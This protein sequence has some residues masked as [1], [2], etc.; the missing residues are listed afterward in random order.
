LVLL[1]FLSLLG[2]ILESEMM[3]SNPAYTEWPSPPSVTRMRAS[4]LSNKNHYRK[5]PNKEYC[6]E[7]IIEDGKRRACGGLRIDKVTNRKNPDGTVDRVV[8]GKYCILCKYRDRARAAEEKKKQ[9]HEEYIKRKQREM[10]E[11]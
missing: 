2:A 8:M 11:G 6:T 4:L 1:D 10:V 7:E 5:V 3:V 9:G